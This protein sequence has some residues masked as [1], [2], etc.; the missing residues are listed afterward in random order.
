MVTPIENPLGHL[1]SYE[2]YGHVLYQQVQAV[3]QFGEHIFPDLE[4]PYCVTVPSEKMTWQQ[5]PPQQ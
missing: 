2:I 1:V 5:L 4:G 3:N